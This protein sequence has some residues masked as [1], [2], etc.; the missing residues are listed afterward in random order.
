MTKKQ[1]V[2]VGGRVHLILL[3]MQQSHILKPHCET[4]VAFPYV[5]R[6]RDEKHVIVTDMW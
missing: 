3:Q 2:N 6:D 5:R 4:V 1:T